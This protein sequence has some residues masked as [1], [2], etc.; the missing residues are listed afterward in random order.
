MIFKAATLK[1]LS[2][3]FLVC[4]LVRTAPALPTEADDGN[5]PQ[6]LIGQLLPSSEFRVGMT[7]EELEGK[8][9]SRYRD[10]ERSEVQRSLNNRK[11]VEISS[12]GRSNYLQRISISRKEND[13]GP[14]LRY[15]FALTSPLSGAR[16]YSIVY[17]V[18]LNASSIISVG[19][20]AEGLRRKWGEPYGR[21]S[22]SRARATYFFNQSGDVIGKDGD[23]CL[24]I[25]PALYRLDE[26]SVEQVVS[27]AGVV[28]S[29]GCSFTRDSML[30][31]KNR[32]VVQSTFYTADIGLQVRDVLKRVA[33]GIR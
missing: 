32:A 14:T 9:E 1:I 21:L 27:V 15:D 12:E 24:P 33:F 25:Y 16:V 19:D 26:K 7:R 29:T 5:S 6:A 8:I 11:D 13:Q 28:T 18:A 2:F 3:L 17:A 30:A 23:P 20:W 31:I 4:F 10:W 22:D